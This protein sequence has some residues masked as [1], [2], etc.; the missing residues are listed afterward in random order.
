[1]T[2]L[3]P[4]LHIFWFLISYFLFSIVTIFYFIF[5]QFAL[6]CIFAS[7]ISLFLGDFSVAR[8]LLPQDFSCPPEFSN[9][10]DFSC[11]PDFSNSQDFSC[12]PE[13]SNPQDFSCPPDLLNQ[14]DFSCPPDFS[15]QQGFSCPPDFSNPQDFSCP[16]DFS[17][18]QDFSCQPDFSNPQDFSSPAW[19]SVGAWILSQ[20]FSFIYS[21]NFSR[22]RVK[23]K[24]CRWFRFA[25][26]AKGKKFRS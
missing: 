6:V 12:P 21:R 13:F 20:K 1:L 7:F 24:L 16:P 19:N 4:I 9:P 18:Q 25:Q 26:L 8:L 10:Q 14:Q 11:P 22:Q 3:C 2:A 23:A 17:N 5:I 15:N